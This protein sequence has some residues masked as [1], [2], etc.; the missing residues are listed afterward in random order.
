[1]VFYSNGTWYG[2]VFQLNGYQVHLTLD[3][4]SIPIVQT[5]SLYTLYLQCLSN[6]VV[7]VDPQTAIASMWIRIQGAKPMRIHPDPY[8]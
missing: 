6:S 8:P 1:M 7:V 2:T 3:A 5:R 4:K